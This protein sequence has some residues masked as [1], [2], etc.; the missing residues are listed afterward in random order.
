MEDT[1]G[2]KIWTEAK[3]E[4]SRKKGKVL[5]NQFGKIGGLKHQDDKT[6]DLLSKTLIWEH[7]FTN[8]R[9]KTYGFDTVN[10][11]AQALNKAA[12]NYIKNL[13]AISAV[14]RNKEPRRYGWSIFKVLDTEPSRDSSFTLEILDDSIN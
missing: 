9:V 8:I 4:S 6:K 13:Q 5:G 3:L 12:P 10:S 14:L 2:G 11:L 7:K 1:L